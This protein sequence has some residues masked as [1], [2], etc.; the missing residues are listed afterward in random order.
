M[1]NTIIIHFPY[2]LKLPCLTTS[3]ISLSNPNL[4]TKSNVLTPSTSCKPQIIQR[5][6]FLAL[7]KILFSTDV[8]PQVFDPYV[9]TGLIHVLYIFTL[10]FHVCLLPH[11]IKGILLKAFYSSPILRV[12]ASLLPLP[13]FI[14][15][16]RLKK[17][18]TLSNSLKHLKNYY[19]SHSKHSYKPCIKNFLSSSKKLSLP[20]MNTLHT[21]LATHAIYLIPLTTHKPHRSILAK[22]TTPPPLSMTF[23][24][25]RLTFNPFSSEDG[26]QWINCVSTPFKIIETIIYMK[27]FI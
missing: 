12:T 2:H 21:C 20:H 10:I 24:L 18:F 8:T 4:T 1:L 27:Q 9:V 14:M 22:T 15:S 11:N 17:L 7:L 23:V 13:P 6:H 19:I 26:F 5:I 3:A 16:P 25:P